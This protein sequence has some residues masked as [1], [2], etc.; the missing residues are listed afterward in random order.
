MSPRSYHRWSRV[1]WLAARLFGQIDQFA[2]QT[3]EYA[4][5]LRQL[6]VS[7]DRL[8]VTG[9]VKYDG[10]LGDRRNPRTTALGDLLDVRADDLVWIVGSTQAPEE[11]IALSIYQKLRPAFPRL[12]LIL[13][14]R[15]KERFDEVANLL[16]RSGMRFV[17]RS[18]MTGPLENR[19]AV[20]LIDT[21]GELGALW[22]LADVA[23]V[24]G[25]LDGQRGG[26]NMIEPAAFGAAVLFG[27]HVWNFRDTVQRLLDANAAI[28]VRDAVDMEQAVQRL[29]ADAGE[30]RRLGA[31][32]RELVR[33]QQGA[34]ER[35][36]DV[37]D[38]MRSTIRFSKAG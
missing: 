7:S 10:V 31:A 28:Q 5:N 32:A 12:R 6:G 26:Q 9:S 17:R 29:L 27:P 13:V 20:L 4:E 3:P 8:T 18:S 22:G 35:T 34:T 25:S 37:L 36:I 2:V 19:D 38:A 1:Q 11:E 16:E 21:F 15:Q 23:F 33:S 14:P 30:R 24:G